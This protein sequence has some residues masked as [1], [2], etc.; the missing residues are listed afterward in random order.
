MKNAH[1]VIVRTSPKDAPYD[2]EI[3]AALIMANFF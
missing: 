3:S 1:R 2:F